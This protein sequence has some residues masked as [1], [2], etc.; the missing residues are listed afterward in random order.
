[1]NE[2]EKK[3]VLIADDDHAIRQLVCTIVQREGLE[4]D[5]AA[6]GVEAIEFLKQHE[7][8]VVLLDL[9]M[10]RIDGFGVIEYLRE[11]PP[12]IKP[13]ILVIS[14]YTD[15]KFKS[16]DPNVVSGVIR[17]PFEVANLG[18]LVRLCA[19]GY[20]EPDVQSWTVSRTMRSKVVELPLTVASTTTD[21]CCC[22]GSSKM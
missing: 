19:H 13:V 14:A 11:H 21:F 4:A 10:P 5:C 9:M 12:S 7:Y 16:V 20:D 6:D 15:E 17:K 8:A 1:M 18:T 2:E 22:A 3:R